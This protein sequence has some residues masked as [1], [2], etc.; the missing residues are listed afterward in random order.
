[1]SKHLDDISKAIDLKKLNLGSSPPR[2]HSDDS[3][4]EK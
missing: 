1:M 2:K 4:L 3:K